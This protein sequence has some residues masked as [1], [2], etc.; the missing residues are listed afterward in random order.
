MLN[1]CSQK[2]GCDKNRVTAPFVANKRRS[3]AYIYGDK[4]SQVKNIRDCF[5]LALLIT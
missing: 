3:K 5:Y 2:K 4:S 1:E